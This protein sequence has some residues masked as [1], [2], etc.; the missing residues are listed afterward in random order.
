MAQVTGNPTS[1]RNHDIFGIY[2][3]LNRFIEEMFKSVSSG[4]SQMNSFDQARLQKYI[5]NIRGF[6]AWV[7]GQP[8]LDLPETAP[9]EYQLVGAPTIALVES[10]EVNDIM[11]MLTVARDEIINSQSSRNPAGLIPFDE[12]RFSAVI[13]KIE[14]FL[15]T[16][17]STLTPLDL[18]ESSPQAPISGPGRTGI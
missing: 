13:N 2:N 4:V 16:Y 15:K 9:R 18:P 11:N 5:D 8:S 14:A 17:V 3:R 12:A 6:V 10:E 7:I 1:T